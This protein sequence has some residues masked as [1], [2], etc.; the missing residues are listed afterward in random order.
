MGHKQSV[1]SPP[2]AETTNQV[3][4]ATPVPLPDFLAAVR[5]ERKTAL[6]AVTLQVIEIATTILNSVETRIHIAKF[7][8][9]GEVRWF[10]F[11]NAKQLGIT[12]G[13]MAAT[14][15][16]VCKV[17]RQRFPEFTALRPS[18]TTNEIYCQII[19]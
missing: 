15:E 16:G 11:L 10:K 1:K 4:G 6:D 17:L 18:D 9:E 19:F 12:P 14:R 5:D 13:Q 8:Q 3:E 2:P 7:A